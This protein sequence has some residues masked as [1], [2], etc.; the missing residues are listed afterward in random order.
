MSAVIYYLMGQLLLFPGILRRQQMVQVDRLELFAGQGLLERRELQDRAE[1]GRHGPV[2]GECL[3]VEDQVLQGSLFNG[4]QDEAVGA[5]DRG[6]YFNRPSLQGDGLFGTVSGADTAAQTDGLVDDGSSFLLG[7]S[8]VKGTVLLTLSVQG[9]RGIVPFDN[10]TTI[11]QV[12]KGTVPFDNFFLHGDGQDGANFLTL[13]AGDAVTVVDFRDVVCRCDGLH[14]AES[15]DGFQG[16]AAAAAAVAHEGGMLADIFPHLDQVV[17]VG[18]LEDF[19]ASAL[20]I[21]RV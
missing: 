3:V 17:A 1:D 21:G 4:L 13:S 20:S 16:F 12:V 7:R 2:V 14:G 10:M 11:M 19:L 15:A 5:V 18:H 8:D 9:V 6:D